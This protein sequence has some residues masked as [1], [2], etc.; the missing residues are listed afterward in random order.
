MLSL[1]VLVLVL[2]QLPTIDGRRLRQRAD[3]FAHYLVNRAEQDT[4]RAGDVVETIV[5]DGKSLTHIFSAVLDSVLTQTDT[6]VH[7]MDLRPVS[8]RSHSGKTSFAVRFSGTRVTGSWTDSAGTKPIDRPLAAA[9]YNAA[10][11]DLVV[12]ASNLAQGAELD[13]VGYRAGVDSAIRLRGSVTGVAVV[14]GRSCW[15]FQGINGDSRVSFWIDQ[16]TRDLRRQVVESPDRAFAIEMKSRPPR[17]VAPFIDA[18]MNGL[19]LEGEGSRLRHTTM[20]FT[21]V[22]PGDGFA[23]DEDM[24]GALL[25]MNNRRDVFIWAYRVPGDQY[26]R[27]ALMTFKGFDGTEEGFRWFVSEILRNGDAPDGVL[28]DSVYWSNQ[29]REYRFASRDKRGVTINERCIPSPARLQPATIACVI[30]SGGFPK[31]IRTLLD[32][33]EYPR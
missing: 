21:L 11:F 29:R 2:A 22:L 18:E 14:D 25:G 33:L 16:A 27:L 19:L 7:T 9:V 15:V 3:T 5:S 31:Q 6:L 23:V 10:S 24:Q 8:H 32:G 4:V 1:A 26:L 30:V 17:E 12:R 20:G 28:E 13:L